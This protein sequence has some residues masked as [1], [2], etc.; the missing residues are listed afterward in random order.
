MRL[1]ETAR[2]QVHGLSKL[3]QAGHQRAGNAKLST[4]HLERVGANNGAGGRQPDADQRAWTDEN[5]TD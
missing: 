5:E 3:V 2:R 4:C 1:D